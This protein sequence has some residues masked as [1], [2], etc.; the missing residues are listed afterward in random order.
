MK[1]TILIAMMTACA[2]V[3]PTTS[4]EEQDLI[5]GLLCDPTSIDQLQ[6]DASRFGASLFYDAVDNGWH[7]C[8]TRQ[9][10]ELVCSSGFLTCSTGRCFQYIAWCTSTTC[11]WY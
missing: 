6:Q 11:D 5:C 8:D 4:T 2:T 3:E 9:D 1:K 10:G 7:S